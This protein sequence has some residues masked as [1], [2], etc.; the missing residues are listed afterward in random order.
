MNGK[1]IRLNQLTAVLACSRSTIYL[2]LDAKSPY[3]DPSFPRPIKLSNQANGRGAVA[4]V[5]AEIHAW[6]ADKMAKRHLPSTSSPQH[7]EA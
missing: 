5:E 4:W 1:L 7:C 2:R 6:I 3:F